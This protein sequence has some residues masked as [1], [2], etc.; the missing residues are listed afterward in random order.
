MKQRYTI[1]VERYTNKAE[2]VY[3]ELIADDA[4][5]AEDSALDAAAQ[6]TDWVPSGGV[7]RNGMTI[8]YMHGVAI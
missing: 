2:H 1:L 4:Y 7:A 6:R 3:V 5:Q 8:R